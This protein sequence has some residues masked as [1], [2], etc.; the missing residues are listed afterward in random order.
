MKSKYEYSSENA[1]GIRVVIGEYDDPTNQK[2]NI[3]TQEFDEVGN[4][5]IYGNSGSGKEMLLEAYLYSFISDYDANQVNA[6]VLD[7]GAE[8]LNVFKDAPQINDV[9][10]SSDSEKIANLFK[11][12][13]KE[14]A[15]RKNSF[16]ILAVRLLRILMKPG[17]FCQE[18]L[19]LSITMQHL[20]NLMM[21]M[22]KC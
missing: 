15:K 7:F 1:K 2:Q 16:Q 11:Y 10:L 9:V 12:L 22:K 3:L 21:N 20:T 19:L 18:F 8:T 6:Y 14:R 13:V 17:K 5:I 4:T